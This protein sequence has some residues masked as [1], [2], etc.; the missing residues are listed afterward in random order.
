M[1]YIRCELNL[2]ARTVLSYGSDLRQF[3]AY[4]QSRHADDYD[5]RLLQVTDLRLWVAHLASNGIAQRSI[6]RKIQ[7][8]RA[9][10][11][12][13]I[14]RHGATVNP[15][16]ELVPARL[17]K[18]LP[19]IVSSDVTRRVIDADIDP[20]DH[21]AFRD[22]LIVDLL[23]STGMRASELANLRDRDINL[24]SGELKV[25][26]KRSKE[27]IIPISSAM[28]AAIRQYIALRPAATAGDPFLRLNDGRPV[29]YATI[30]ASVKRGFSA[31]ATHPTPHWLR[32][33]CATDMLNNGAGL[34]AV[35]ELLGHASLATTQIYTHLSYRELKQNYQ[36]AHPRAKK[37]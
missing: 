15:A 7:T 14:K 30:N 6:R 24:E 21:T 3:D 31:E 32:H 29:S 34:N 19:R 13:L 17:P 27:R 1:T 26:G 25:V 33:S 9:F 23:Y 22:R 11:T 10:Y 16:A 4:M 35:K 5:P 8:L 18:S 28:T 37:S 20:A 36:L 2:S 12:Y